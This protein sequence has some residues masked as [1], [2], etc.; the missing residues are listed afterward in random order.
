MVQTPIAEIK[1]IHGDWAAHIFD[2]TSFDE[3]WR[4]LQIHMDLKHKE[5]E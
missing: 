2:S 4:W 3:A 1:C 5:I